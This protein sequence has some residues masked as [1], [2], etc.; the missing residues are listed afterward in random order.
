M[1][2]Q[3]K[4]PSVW[5]VA[6]RNI[7]ISLEEYASERTG[8]RK[9]CYACSAFVVKAFF[10]NNASQHDG[11]GSECNSCHNRNKLKRSRKR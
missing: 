8:G 2:E 11:L 9:W 3:P 7:G 4:Y 6:A 1:N 10:R 5:K